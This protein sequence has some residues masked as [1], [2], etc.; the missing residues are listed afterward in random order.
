[1]TA[2]LKEQNGEPETMRNGLFA[3]GTKRLGEI[4][5]RSASRAEGGSTAAVVLFIKCTY[6][7]YFV[8]RSIQVILPGL[9]RYFAFCQDFAQDFVIFLVQFASKERTS[10]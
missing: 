7:T 3:L 1:M 5:A 9:T 8:F 6:D 2:L 10:A 4:L